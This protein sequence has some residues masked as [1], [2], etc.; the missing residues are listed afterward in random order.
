MQGF[1][2]E[3]QSLDVKTLYFKGV[4]MLGYEDLVLNYR[5]LKFFPKNAKEFSI[6]FE[7]KHEAFF[8]CSSKK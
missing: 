6:I 7:K 3:I 5:I 8:H 4:L 2:I 1:G